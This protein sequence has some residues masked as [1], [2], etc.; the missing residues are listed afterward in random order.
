MSSTWHGFLCCLLW[1]W[2]WVVVHNELFY[3][4]THG[5]WVFRLHSGVNA[6][7]MQDAYWVN[8]FLNSLT[9][10][11][12]VFGVY[13]CSVGLDVLFSLDQ[14]RTGHVLCWVRVMLLRRRRQSHCCLFKITFKF[15]MSCPLCLT[16][17]HDLL[18][19]SFCPPNSPVLLLI[20]GLLGRGSGAESHPESEAIGTRWGFL[21]LGGKVHFGFIFKIQI[22][23]LLDKNGVSGQYYH[24]SN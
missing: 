3:M 10:H 23:I 4:G 21:L 22:W 17:V 9:L 2:T 7:E 11:V 24:K 16:G 12:P 15:N 8:H 14:K 19:P 5:M 18:N 20:S 13:H 6:S 1:F